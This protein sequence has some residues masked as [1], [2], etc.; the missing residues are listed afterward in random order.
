MRRKRGAKVERREGGGRG[1]GRG[2]GKFDGSLAPERGTNC[3]QRIKALR[4][5]ASRFETFGFGFTNI[6]HFK[7]RDSR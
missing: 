3:P 4:I 1:G 7:G 6:G 2:G 5:K